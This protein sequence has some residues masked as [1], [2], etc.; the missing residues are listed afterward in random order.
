MPENTIETFKALSDEIRL[1]ILRALSQAELSVAELVQ[2]LGLPQSTVSRHLKPLRDNA[3]VETR[4]EATSIYYRKGAALSDQI[5]SRLVTRSLDELP[6]GPQDK[7]SVRR[8]LDARRSRSRDFFDHI[9]GR[10][11]SLTQPG[12]GWAALAAGLAAG[13]SGLAVA[14]LGAGE[15]E[16]TLLLARYASRVTAVDL[17]PRML[18]LVAERAAQAG[19]SSRIEVAEGDLEALPLSSDSMDAVFL[20]QALHHAGNPATALREAARVLRPGGRLILL[21]LARHEQEWVREE[22]ADQWL[23]FDEDQLATWIAEAGLALMHLQ[24]IEGATPELAVLLAVACD[25]PNESSIHQS[26]QP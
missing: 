21:D 17:S 19:L 7:A 5:L 23:G 10:Y 18:K 24:R 15:G 4:R 8:I 25:S 14:D 11:G 3:L 26:S 6:N 16:L 13:F 22:W 9:A 12:G 1:R 20:S 2:V